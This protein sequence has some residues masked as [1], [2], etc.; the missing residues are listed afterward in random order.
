MR[1]LT[2]LALALAMITAGSLTSCSRTESDTKPLTIGASVLGTSF[3]AVAAMDSGMKEKAKELGVE[4]VI[5]DAGGQASKQTNDVADLLSRGVDGV[6]I[7]AVDSKTVAASADAVT[8]AGIPLTSAFTTLGSA[9]CAYAGSVAH[10]GFDEAGWA[11]LQGSSAVTLLPDGGDVAIIDGSPGV[12][13]SKIR[14]DGF[15]AELKANQGIKVVA[16]QPGNFDRATALTAM[17]NILQANP[18]LDL[19]YAP[20]DNMAVGAIQAIDK[21]GLTGKIK[22]LGLGGSKDGL[23]AVQDGTM[24]ATVYS[25]LKEG[26]AL[27]VETTVK[28]LRGEANGD[29]QCITV[30]QALVDA[31][32]VKDYIDKGEY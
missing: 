15:V 13:A 30:A 31:N 18:G 19:V 2:T 23:K 12:Q 14:H 3:P 5:V 8:A 25:S 7:N 32:N 29:E 26:G 10:V 4:L 6:I 1:K 22:V 11:K 20:D 17:E 9:Q 28:K 21:A 16:S 24:A 27:A